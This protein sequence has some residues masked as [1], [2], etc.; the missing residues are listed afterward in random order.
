L[1]FLLICT[2]CNHENILIV[3]LLFDYSFYVC[4]PNKEAEVEREN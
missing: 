2:K 3:L 4:V 1:I